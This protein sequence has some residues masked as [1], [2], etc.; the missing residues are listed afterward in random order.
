MLS[1]GGRRTGPVYSPVAIASGQSRAR[2]NNTPWAAR[3]A[4]RSHS[5]ATAC[6]AASNA[7][8]TPAD[9]CELLD[10]VDVRMT[11]T[12]SSGCT[13]RPTAAVTCARR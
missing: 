7:K 2:P 4:R 1:A 9:T 10:A 5:S 13:H 6:A 12:G 11:S 8:R 3:G